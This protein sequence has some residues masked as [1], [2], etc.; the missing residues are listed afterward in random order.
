[1][2]NI[3]RSYLT[4]IGY[5]ID[6]DSYRKFKN[7]LADTSKRMSELGLVAIAT[8]TEVTA[9]VI[10]MASNLE[11]LYFA[12][13]RTGATAK[14]IQALEYGAE[15]IGISADQAR[16][17]LEGMASALRTQPGLVGLLKSLNL[18]PNQDKVELL[19]NLV[20]RLRKMPFYQG[21]AYASLFGIDE[22][23][24]FMME[25]NF[26]ELRKQ[27]EANKRINP[28]D[29]AKVKR[30]HDFMVQVREV[31]NKFYILAGIV[32]SRI[33]PILEK[34]LPLVGGFLDKMIALDE[35]TGGVSSVLFGI[36]T[37]LLS[38]YGAAK[39]LRI[40]G[41]FLGLG[42]AE[43]GA[44]FLAALKGV[45]ATLATIGL[46]AVV[47]GTTAA[48]LTT[49]RWRQELAGIKDLY[50]NI[51]EYAKHPL[52]TIK[53]MFSEQ[54][55][56]PEL[57]K[58]GITQHDSPEQKA[59]RHLVHTLFPSISEDLPGQ[60]S[61]A[62]PAPASDYGVPR[63]N[64]GNVR[65]WPGVPTVA[66]GKIGRFAQFRSD[67]EGLS[68]MAGNLLAYSRRGVN[69]IGSIV[70]RWAP[71]S[72]NDT[73]AYIADVSKRMGINAGQGLDLTNPQTLEGLMSAMIHH[74]QGRDPYPA[75]LIHEMA[76]YQ[77]GKEGY[78]H[79][80]NVRIDQRTEINVNGSGDPRS[81][82]DHVLKGQQ[83]VNADIVRNMQ[84]NTK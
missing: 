44:G 53:K 16:S 1:M 57:R 81:V 70:S 58:K 51:G 83:S 23:T 56:D 77:L 43:E 52:D 79:G 6:E 41:G 82:G 42:T 73:A 80:A 26:D 4:S 61:T 7:N 2:E 67:F 39:A 31:G 13:Q 18:N 64:P 3:L 5:K 50:Q 40:L 30:F 14:N 21:A 59:I 55:Y 78:G 60:A 15:Q 32:A 71:R 62:Q 27:M 63:H 46:A 24:L 47:S 36:G 17:A 9:S 54:E 49:K 29:D 84:G 10:K 45:A 11:K 65:K 75:K 68:A 66:V 76:T 8:A 25:K 74:E 12:S 35:A 34:L 19:I 22:K 38:L 48:W 37:A 20:D 72:E 69:T 28:I 33:V